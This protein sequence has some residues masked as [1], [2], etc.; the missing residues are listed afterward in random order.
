M[1]KRNKI[2]TLVILLIL[3]YSD[4]AQV[5][6]FNTFGE[7]VENDETILSNFLEDFSNFI[8]NPSKDECVYH[9]YDNEVANMII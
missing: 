2:L 4:F 5:N 8:N 9:G 1:V 6:A 7:K 3:I